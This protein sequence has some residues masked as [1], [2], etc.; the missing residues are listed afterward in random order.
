MKILQA[1]S[2]LFFVVLFGC[3]ATSSI[4]FDYDIDEDFNQHNTF[5]VCEDDLLVKNITYPNYDNTKIRTFLSE[6]VTT[7]LEDFGLNT[8]MDN[9]DLQVGFRL[10]ITEETVNFRDCSDEGEF[11]YWESCTVETVTYTTE[12]LTIY[13]SNLEKNQVVWQASMPCNMNKSESNLASHIKELVD[14]LFKT[15]PAIV[16][17]ES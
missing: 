15:Y 10:V 16:K 6:E 5:V 4:V 9:P 8:D 7:K 1:I 11:L 13:V 12:T 17:P 3:A 2:F 14:T